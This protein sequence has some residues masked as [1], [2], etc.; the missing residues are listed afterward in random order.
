MFLR[1]KKRKVCESVFNDFLRL[2]RVDSQNI[3]TPIPLK[4]L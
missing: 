2:M 1:D 4:K 3:F